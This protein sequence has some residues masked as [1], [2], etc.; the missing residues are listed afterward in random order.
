MAEP[1]PARNT[2]LLDSP[3]NNLPLQLTPLVGR[4]TEVS[5]VLALVR[6][7][8][9]RLVTLTGPG[10]TGKTRL[11]L[12]AAA[13]LIDSFADGIF[14]VNLAPTD[15]PALVPGTI[16]TTLGLRE[17]SDLAAAVQLRAAL[18]DKHLLLLLDSFE[19]LAAA[20]AEIA[21]L[22]AAAPRLI[23]LITSRE[24]LHVYGEHEFA[25]PPAATST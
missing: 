14:F 5:A 2:F 7:P 20:A 24:A 21:A 15:D 1:P 9:V 8:G 23:V 12:Q 6:T 4:Q 3:P 17:G 11:A 10:G 18:R 16:A 19:H 13:E 25:V 22:L